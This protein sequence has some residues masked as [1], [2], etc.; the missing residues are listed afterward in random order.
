MVN[1]SDTTK[2][3]SQFT[4]LPPY[5]TPI[6]TP[7]AT[8]VATFRHFLPLQTV[9]EAPFPLEEG[10]LLLRTIYTCNAKLVAWLL[11]NF[12]NLDNVVNLNIGISNCKTTFETFTNL[13]H[14]ILFTP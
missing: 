12:V 3:F 2:T 1:V 14:V 9:K 4:H 6:F 7:F 13:R 8:P 10:S 11:D 5:F